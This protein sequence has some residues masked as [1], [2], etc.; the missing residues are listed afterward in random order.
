MPH[1][2]LLRNLRGIF[3]S[4]EIESKEMKEILTQLESGVKTGRLFPFNYYAAY[5]EIERSSNVDFKN[6]IQNSLEKI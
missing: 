1:F 5:R 4:G 3:S 2:A 6:A